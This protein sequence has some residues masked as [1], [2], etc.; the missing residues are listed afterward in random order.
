MTK[1][2]TPTPAGQMRLCKGGVAMTVKYNYGSKPAGNYNYKW[3]IK[4]IAP[5]LP[6]NDRVFFYNDQLKWRNNSKEIPLELF[7]NICYWKSH[8][9]FK[10]VLENKKCEVNDRWQKVRQYLSKAP[11][12]DNSLR[13]AFNEL[14]QLR[15][16]G[17]PTASAL[18]TA[19]N[20]NEFG[21]I[22]FKV[23]K[24]LSIGETANISSYLKL[25]NR[26]LKLRKELKIDN[27]SLRQIEL[28]IWYYYPI[29]NTGEVVI[30]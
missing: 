27:C 13:C 21:I 23:L 11:F 4:S 19:W 20:P 24:V 6:K 17:V 18:L 26:L 28:A 29:Q 30:K 16:V 15:G 3:F 9:R 22:D 2:S 10:K 8:R 12:Q 25:R 14:I 1:Q 5:I 7:R